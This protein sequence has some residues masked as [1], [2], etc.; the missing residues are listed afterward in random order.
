MEDRLSTLPDD[1][2][3]QIL[4]LLPLIQAVRTCVLSRRWRRFW[5]QAQIL[6]IVDNQVDSGGQHG[7]FVRVVDSILSAY[8]S[9][10]SR[11]RCFFQIS[12]SREDNVNVDRLTSWA[13]RAS[14]LFE[15]DFVLTVETEPE[16]SDEESEEE[17]EL[18][19][20]IFELPY[21]EF[22]K[23]ITLRLSDRFLCLALPTS[24]GA[25]ASLTNL[26]LMSVCF[27]DGAG[28]ALGELVSSRCP[29]LVILDMR[30]IQ[31][32]TALTLRTESLTHL[33]LSQVQGLRLLDVVAP[34]LHVMAV[35]CCFVESKGA[36]LRISTP[37]LLRVEWLDC[38]P[39]HTEVAPTDDLKSMLV[40]EIPPFTWDENFKAHSNFDMILSHF[41]RT[42]A[43]ELHLPIRPV[44]SI[45][46]SIHI[47]IF[48]IFLIYN[49]S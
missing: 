10:L 27:A 23:R 13:R 42:K 28:A 39:E 35:H 40:G 15:G 1:L 14:E 21:F 24:A 3:L 29:C 16:D 12:I 19:M 37:S 31:G 25:F 43:L 7:R 18:E 22:A 44:S 33:T 9:R 49:G 8:A 36:V 17:E 30:Y 34:K 6:N 5:T 46:C 47:F 20:E 26:M 48:L 41:K 4:M 38:C 32:V 11:A 45:P 2:L